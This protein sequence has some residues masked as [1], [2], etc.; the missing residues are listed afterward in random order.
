ME[1]IVWTVRGTLRALAAKIVFLIIIVCL[2]ERDVLHVN[3]MKL[4]L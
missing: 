2:M 1:V 3:V 4:D